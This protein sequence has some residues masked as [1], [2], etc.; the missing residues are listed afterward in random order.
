MSDLTLIAISLLIPFLGTSLGSL[1]VLIFKKEINIKF[2]KSLI[3]FS[4]GIMIAASIWSLL[5]P[6]IDMCNNMKFPWFAASLGFMIGVF[7]LLILDKVICKVEKK[8]MLT[9][10]VTLHN[11]PEGM[12][13]GVAVIGALSGNSFTLTLALALTIGIAIQNIPEGAIISMPLRGSGI[14]RWKS[15]LYGIASGAVEP[16]FGFLT[17]IFA[18]LTV[19]LLPYLLGFAAGA[20]IYVTV[21]ELIPEAQMGDHQ[22]IG[23]LGL[24]L[25]FV[26][27]MILDVALG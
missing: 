7:L 22:G 12:A 16:I 14:P 6:A 13:A 4:A 27:M 8:S 26:L 1:I 23:V 20:M 2:Q 15:A 18:S 3:G 19:P 21:H 25:G 11:I 5:I 9:L 17:I 24:S 10:A